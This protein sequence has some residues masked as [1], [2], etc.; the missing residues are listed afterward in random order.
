MLGS[1]KKYFKVYIFIKIFITKVQIET[2]A[3]E[4]INIQELFIR[5]GELALDHKPLKLKSSAPGCCTIV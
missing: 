4:S 5:A 1:L 2:S 3:K